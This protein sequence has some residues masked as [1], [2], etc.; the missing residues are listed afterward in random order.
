M[1]RALVAKIREL[2]FRTQQHGTRLELKRL[3]LSGLW[4]LSAFVTTQAQVV[5]DGSFG[6]SGA[7]TGPNYNI[8][9]AAGLMR[10]NNLFHSF[11]QFDLRAGDVATFSGPANIQNILGRVTGG[12]PSS[13]D[14]TIRSG[15]A[16]ANFYFINPSG[17]IFGP[18]ASVDVSGAFAVSTANYLKLADG[19][20]FMA[21][22]GADDSTLSSAPVSAFGFLEGANGGVEVR[23]SL[24]SSPGTPLAVIGTTVTVRDGAS[25]EALGS[26]INL[27]GVSAAGEVAPSIPGSIKGDLAPAGAASPPGSVVIRGGRLVIENARVDVSNTGGDLVLA[28]SDSVEVLNGGQLTTGASGATRGGNIIIEAPKIAIDGQNGPLPTRI[29]AETGSDDAAGMGG[30]VIIRSGSLDLEHGAEISVSTF[31]A[32][33]AGRID[34]TTGAMRV[35]GSDTFNFLTQISANAAPVSG[36]A[37]GAGGQIV[38]RADS[39]ELGQYATVSASSLG[40]ANAGSIDLTAHS[41]SIKDSSVTTYSSGAGNGGDIRVA[42]DELTLD[43]MFGSITA[44]ALGV[45]SQSPAGHGGNIDIRT[46]SLLMIN[47]AAISASTYGDGNAG[48]IQI[49]AASV[50]LETGH[51]QPGIIPGISS[52]S[53]LSFDGTPNAGNGG[54]I[55]INA[56]SLSILNGMMISVETSTLGRGGNIDIQTGSLRVMTDSAISASTY[57]NGNAGSILINADSV[58]LDTGRP[59]AGVIPGISSSSNVSLDGSANTGKGGDVF[60]NA[61]SLSMLNGMIISAGTATPGAGGSIYITADSVSIN[62]GA[63]IRSSSE[64]SGRAGTITLESSGGVMLSGGASIS[65]AALQSSAGDINVVSDLEVRVVDSAVIARAGPGGG[66]NITIQAPQLI[67]L[68]RGSLDT[69]AVGDGGNLTVQTSMFVVNGS[70]LISK[71]SSANGGNISILSDYFLQSGTIID[72]SAPFGLAGAVKVTAPDL[73]LSGS[74]IALP[75]SL[76]DAESQMRPDCAVRTSGDISSFVILGRG[77]LPLEPGGF[78]PSQAP[79]SRD[80]KE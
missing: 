42:S 69:Q 10:G 74:L 1:I 61:G 68:L 13:I 19:A 4:I 49:H 44:L 79:S 56:D 50:D 71:S 24:R 2:E 27:T 20:R 41:I 18:N 25:L 59:H 26:Q 32:A 34:I 38:I 14:G 17:V 7:L 52:T 39:L 66:G 21:A 77:G 55:S 76:L 12:N 36:T 48:N 30:N 11:S 46:S 5:L 28:L 64:A 6:T 62:N 31:G 54:N 8:A 80:E 72:A 23:G 73:D 45:N 67:Y 29:A 70:D 43:G 57:G 15:I 9:A 65:T 51:P 40:D 22:L 60:L 16:G 53:S 47:D 78:I 75:G 58:V 35:L 33:D 37:S 63:S 3:A